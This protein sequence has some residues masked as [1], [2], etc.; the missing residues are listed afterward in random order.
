M[1]LAPNTASRLSMGRKGWGRDRVP[2]AW[3]GSFPREQT[4]PH[5]HPSQ[6]LLHWPS[7]PRLPFAL[8]GMGGGPD[9]GLGVLET[10]RGLSRTWLLLWS[11]PS[12][13]LALRGHPTSKGVALF[14]PPS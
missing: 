6:H 4:T 12:L 14:F 8:T 2:G 1:G 9:L 11:L 7:Q 13:F 3:A 10:H 5:P